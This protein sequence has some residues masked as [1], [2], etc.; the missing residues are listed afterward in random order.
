MSTNEIT[1]K[2]RDLKELRAEIEELEAQARSIEDEIKAEM[3]TRDVD[4]MQVDVFKVRYKTVTS[5]RLDSKAFKQTHSELYNQ[6]CKTTE[7]RRFSV[8]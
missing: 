3:L 2:V 4:E 1:S 6:Y 7:Y 5:S 8:A